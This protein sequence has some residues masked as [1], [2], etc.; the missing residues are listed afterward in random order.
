M[1]QSND[2][3]RYVRYINVNFIVLEMIVP[4]AELVT[5]EQVDLSGRNSCV[6]VLFSETS[7]ASCMSRDI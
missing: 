3:Y 1:I 6:E 5:F 2:P 4:R 7:I